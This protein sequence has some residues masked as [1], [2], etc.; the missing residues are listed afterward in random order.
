MSQNVPPRPGPSQHTT[1]HHTIPHHTTPHHTTPHHT[2]PYDFCNSWKSL[3]YFLQ[4]LENFAI[5][6]EMIVTFRNISSILGN[7]CNKYCYILRF[8][9]TYCNKYCNTLK[10]YCNTILLESS[11]VHLH[12]ESVRS[13]KYIQ[14][15]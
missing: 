9:N 5:L 13:S 2:A 14:E 3:H 7:I 15:E 10:W 6:F 11:L 8:Y 1:P 4:Q 12:F